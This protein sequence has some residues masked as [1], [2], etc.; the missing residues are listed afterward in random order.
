MKREPVHDSDASIQM[1]NK[2]LI[3]LTN[4]IF[5]YLDMNKSFISGTIEFE[6]EIDSTLKVDI[7]N[8]SSIVKY[9]FDPVSLL[10][11]RI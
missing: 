10:Y 11:L 4:T 1:N 7:N 2:T 3:N 6:V 5:H 9:I 8:F